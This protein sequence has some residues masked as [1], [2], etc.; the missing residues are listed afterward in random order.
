MGL[1][2]N[3]FLKLKIGSKKGRLMD[4]KKR[5]RYPTNISV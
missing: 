2:D 1:R 5:N 4:L 3:S